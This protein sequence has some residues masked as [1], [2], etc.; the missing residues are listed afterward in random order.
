M[1]TKVQAFLAKYSIST[2]SIAMF[3]AAVAAAYYE[4]PEFHNAVYGLY[5]HFPQ[6]AKTVVTVS[7]ALYM[8]YRNGQKAKPAN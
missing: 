5:G 4:V 8:W 1:L 7:L 3:L 2:H 6:W